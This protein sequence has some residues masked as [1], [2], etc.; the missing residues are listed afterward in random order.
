M[1]GGRIAA[2]LR[3]TDAVG[4][5]EVRTAPEID[6]GFRQGAVGDAGAGAGLPDGGHGAK[7]RPVRG[8][9]NLGVILLGVVGLALVAVGV[10]YLAVACGSLPGFLGPVHGDRTPR[11]GRGLLA[12]ALAAIVLLPVGHALMRRRGRA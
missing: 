12:L 3:S 10:V 1:Q 11:T 4:A 6:G 9:G 8:D 5:E 2:R 7:V